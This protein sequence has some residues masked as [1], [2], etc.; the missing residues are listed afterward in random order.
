MYK[1][2]ITLK[3]C[4]QYKYIVTYRTNFVKN[5][6]KDF[7][8]NVNFIY[9]FRFKVYAYRRPASTGTVAEKPLSSSRDLVQPPAVA[10]D[11]THVGPHWM[12]PLDRW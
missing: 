7:C 4:D 8:F 1:I 9:L 2:I 10:T 6:L 12:A 5:Q 3:I 11:P